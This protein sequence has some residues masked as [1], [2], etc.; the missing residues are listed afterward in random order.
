MVW[1]PKERELTREEAIE[2]AKKVLAPFWYGSKPLVMAS[3]VGKDVRI[4]P[5]D[6]AFSKGS[7]MVALLDPFSPSG[8]GALRYINQMHRRHH[9][10]DL[11]TC[12]V[13]RS[14]YE[15]A[16][17]RDQLQVLLEELGISYPVVL[18]ADGQLHRGFEVSQW[19]GVSYRLYHAGECRVKADAAVVPEEWETEIQAFLRSRDPGLAVRPVL[20]TREFDLKVQS[21][22]VQS[23]LK[24]FR[25]LNVSG[26]WRD[27][28]SG[29][30]SVDP[31]S[32]LEF[33]IPARRA[34]LLV[35]KKGKPST[36]AL[37]KVSLAG[38]PVFAEDRG[39]SLIELDDGQ[40]AIHFKRARLF[41]LLQRNDS[42]SG[43]RKLRLEAVSTDDLKII[44][45]RLFIE[46]P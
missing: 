11:N 36:T 24:N 27:E 6:D 3:F 40:T 44:F 38:I 20:D 7:W 21:I 39:V 14:P 37:V 17:D 13:L 45:H 32:A 41:E 28:G 10:H 22:S 15:F 46:E 30:F 12:V 33:E 18:D 9:P 23:A 29:V 35:E 42:A 4:F 31:Q 43:P 5:I 2:E 8:L 16:R 26:E 25:T 34:F 19:E 1:K